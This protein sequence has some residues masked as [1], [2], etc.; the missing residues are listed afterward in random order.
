MSKM[1]ITGTSAGIGLQTAIVVAKAGHS[2][3]ATMRNLERGTALRE[4]VTHDRLPISIL[5]IDVD[6]DESVASATAA[7]RSQ[8]GS[9]DV[10]VNEE[11]R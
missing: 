1:L 8:F 5:P 2:V 4:A 9:I 10:L 7:I 11:T 3:I 6:S